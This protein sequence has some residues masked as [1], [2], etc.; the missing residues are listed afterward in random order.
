MTTETECLRSLREAAARLGESPSK[1]QYEE[2]GLTPAASTISRVVGGRNDV[3]VKVDLSTNPS[4]GS[5]TA[6]K[7][8]R[9]E[10]P[11]GVTWEA[12]SVD[13][14]WHYRHTELNA[15]RT[16]SRRARLRMWVCERKAASDG[17]A[18]C[19][20]SD[21]ACLEFRHRAPAE[22]ERSVSELV[23]YGHGRARL[24]EEMARCDLLCANCH[25]KEH[26]SVSEAVSASDERD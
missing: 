12:L 1:A 2:L 26:Y 22:K 11:E 15:E 21:P 10:L 14:R 18:R 24:R 4:T 13:Q 16:R 23:S 19:S 7:P 8:A 9:V 6:P 5:R 20:E 17:C 25:R 3:K